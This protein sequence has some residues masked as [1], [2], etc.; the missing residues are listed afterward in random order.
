M[1]RFKNKKEGVFEE[2]KSKINKFAKKL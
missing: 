1:L 2:I